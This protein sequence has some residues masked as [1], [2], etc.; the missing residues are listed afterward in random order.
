MKQFVLEVLEGLLI[1]ATD[2]RNLAR[3]QFSRYFATKEMTRTFGESGYTRQEI[4]ETYESDVYKI[5]NAIS[6]LKGVAK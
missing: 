3:K 2:N 4:L 5:E 6:W 1:N